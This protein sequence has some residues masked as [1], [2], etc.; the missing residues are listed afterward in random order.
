MRVLTFQRYRAILL[1]F[2]GLGLAGVWGLA[3]SLRPLDGDLTRVG[4]YTE[5]DFHWTK[6][7][8][9]FAGNLF[10]ITENLEDYDRY[11]DVV[12]LGDSFTCDQEGRRFG[13]QNFFLKRTGLSMIVFDTRKYW[14]LQVIE[15]PGF[16]RHPP[17]FFVF[18]SVERYLYD[19]AAY[20][21][22]VPLG[23]AEPVRGKPVLTLRETD[24]GPIPME[25]QKARSCLD[26]DYVLGYLNAV[27]QRWFR[28][29]NQVLKLPLKQGG[30]FSSRTDREMLVYFDEV[31]KNVLT[32]QNLAKLRA[33][34]LR[35]QTLV[36]SNGFTRFLYLIAP[37][38]SSIYAPY[39]AN[40]GDSTMNLV[41]NASQEN[42]LHL[43]RTDRILAS[44][45]A[46]GKPDIYLP[47]DSHWSGTGHRLVADGLVDS[48]I[49]SGI[50][51][52]RGSTD[53]QKNP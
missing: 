14:P 28:L 21:V 36:E 42:R 6:A 37:D 53:E 8:P 45:I 51:E 43:V 25:L 38:K 26:S 32:D 4:G 17:R 29:N 49:A 19:R 22:D 23:K 27:M 12:V 48:L 1:G 30:L 5:N 11:Y 47:N 10:R 41:G 35:L 18:E 46:A 9:T 15:S 2:F 33:G 39:L 13:W 34:M 52:K 7:Q 40:A 3:V 20:F 50:L 16:R 31:A 44:A 24:S